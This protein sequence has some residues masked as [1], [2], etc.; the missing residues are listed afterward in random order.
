[1]K[2]NMGTIDRGIRLLVAG[3]LGILVAANIIEGTMMWVAAAIGA[4]FVLTS[5]VSV[6]PLYS[7]LGF[8]TCPVEQKD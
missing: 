8:R 3:V 4:V 2:K 7:V 6:C 5:L 1:M